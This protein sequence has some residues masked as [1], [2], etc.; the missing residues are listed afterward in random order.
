M[1]FNYTLFGES[2]GQYFKKGTEQLKKKAVS[3]L[4]QAHCG[5]GG[6]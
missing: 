2:Y 5:F 6:V 4:W 3:Q 1:N